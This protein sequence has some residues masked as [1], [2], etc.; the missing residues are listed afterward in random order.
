MSYRS[1]VYRQRN[2][3]THDEKAK[4]PFFSKRNDISKQGSKNTFF[5]AKLSVN[6]PGDKYEH[7]ADAVANDVV[8]RNNATP[9]VQQ[10]SISN[11][12]RL[13]TSLEDEKLATNDARMERD[14]EI[15]QKPIQ[16][17]DDP[18]KDEEDKDRS[19]AVQA[20][21]DAGAN[22]ASANVS[23]GIE[24]SSGRG[25]QL[26]QKTL[27]EMNSSFGVDF[28]GVN[29]HDD[30]D[31]ANMNNELQAQAFTHG[32]DIYFNRG[33]Y[34]PESA[35]GKFLLAHELTH[36]VQ[37][38]AGRMIQKKDAK[39][40]KKP[41]TNFI[42]YTGGQSGIVSVFKDGAAIFSGYAVSGQPGSKENQKGVGPT[43]NGVYNIHP[44]KINSPVTKVQDGTCGANAISS[45]FQ[46]LKSNEKVPCEHP[47]HYCS[48][49]CSESPVNNCFTPIGCWGENRIKI[50][51][52]ANVTADDGKKVHRSGFYFHGGN[53]SNLASSGCI[54]LLDNNFFTKARELKGSV[55]VFVGTACPGFDPSALLFSVA[56]AIGWD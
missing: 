9:I 52:S 27:Q 4:E 14:K 25:N 54:K 32:R 43:P 47:S 39:K 44:Q 34:D 3:H 8:N 13:S 50:E 5:Q 55:P 30:K 48:E 31:A 6:K 46:E 29:I 56:Q 33:K 18:V 45:G 11:I 41:L 23:S 15:Q 40:K 51:G 21:H 26:P 22:T 42:C 20:K 1:R 24:N 16:L 49:T 17:M 53:P 19:S 7:E 35:Q 10:K 12:Q 36:V 37:Q 38:V 2:L 28:S